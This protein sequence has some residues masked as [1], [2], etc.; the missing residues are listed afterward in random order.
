MNRQTSGRIG[1]SLALDY[2][3]K[4]GYSIVTSN[5]TVR[6]GELDAVVLK[7]GVLVFVEIKAKTSIKNGAPAKEITQAK[8]AALYRTAMQF[9]KLNGQNKKVKASLFGIPLYRRYRSIR[10]DLVEILIEGQGIKRLIH[11]K[12]I[13]KTEK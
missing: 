10:F 12:N 3:R 9:I 7:G 8:K 5:Y 1:E 13:I 6:G 4:K 11:T 2:L